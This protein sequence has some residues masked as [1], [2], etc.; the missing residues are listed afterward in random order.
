MVDED[1][2]SAFVI[3]QLWDQVRRLAEE[4]SEPRWVYTQLLEDLVVCLQFQELPGKDVTALLIELFRKYRD[5]LL[6]LA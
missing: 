1:D 3:R 2:I 6:Q 4:L 5:Q